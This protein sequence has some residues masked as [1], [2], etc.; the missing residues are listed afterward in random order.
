MLTTTEKYED[1]N[2]RF[3]YLSKDI[4]IK[5]MNNNWQDNN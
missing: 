2:L 5:K 3:W 4:D 1:R